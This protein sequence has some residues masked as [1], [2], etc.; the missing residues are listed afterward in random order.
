MEDGFTGFYDVSEC[1]QRNIYCKGFS[2]EWGGGGGGW[3][4]KD[5]FLDLL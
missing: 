5:Y 4:E 2:W 3:G 1:F